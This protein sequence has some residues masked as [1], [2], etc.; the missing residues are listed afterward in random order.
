MNDENVSP[1]VQV[2]IACAT[3]SFGIAAFAMFILHEISNGG[4][5]AIAMMT[6]SPAVLGI[7]IAYFLNRDKN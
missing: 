5:W 4:M 1:Y 3:A 2:A 6:F 7:G